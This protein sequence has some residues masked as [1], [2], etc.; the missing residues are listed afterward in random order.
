MERSQLRPG[1]ERVR[2]FSAKGQYRHEYFLATQQ[3]LPRGNSVPGIACDLYPDSKPNALPR[4]TGGFYWQED[5]YADFRIHAKHAND[6]P[7]IYLEIIR[8]LQLLGKA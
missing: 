4:C 1:L 2:F 8:V 7:E 5:V 6:W 3:T